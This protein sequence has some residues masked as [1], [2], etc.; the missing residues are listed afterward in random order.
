MKNSMYLKPL[1]PKAF[2]ICLLVFYYFKCF[3]CNSDISK[4][5]LADQL[6]LEASEGTIEKADK[7]I[8]KYG[9][10][11]KASNGW[12]AIQIAANNG[13]LKA[14]KFL[15]EKGADVRLN[16]FQSKKQTALYIAAEKSYWDIV[17]LLLDYGSTIFFNSSKEF[18]KFLL[19]YSRKMIIDKRLL[20]KVC[21]LIIDHSKEEPSLFFSSCSTGCLRAFF[22]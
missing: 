21:R 17:Q 6:Y 12:A 3:D 4:M 14:V 16:Y 10:N 22:F 1:I 18:E 7:I 11:V 20:K 15:L 2:F 8:L 5:D 19:Y 9:I 13:N